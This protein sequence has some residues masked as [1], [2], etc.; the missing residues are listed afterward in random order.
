[1]GNRFFYIILGATL[2]NVI[3]ACSM[4]SK[5]PNYNDFPVRAK[6]MSAFMKCLDNDTEN[7]CK[8]ICKKYSKK[9]KCKEPGVV[10]TNLKNLINDG[11]VVL[12]KELFMNLIRGNK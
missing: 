4:G 9:N 3:I 1:M 5:R 12:S 8:Y 6:S 7:V 10:K 2:F 11:Y